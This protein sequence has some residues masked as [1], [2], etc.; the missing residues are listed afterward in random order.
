MAFQTIH[1]QSNQWKTVH[2]IVS[3]KILSFQ[4]MKS[5][6]QITK[7]AHL[8][9]FRL[10]RRIC[11]A[12]S[13]PG[14]PEVLSNH[15]DYTAY[16]SKMMWTQWTHLSPSPSNLPNERNPFM[17]NLQVATGMLCRSVGIFLEYGCVRYGHPTIGI[18]CNGYID[19]INP[20]WGMT[21]CMGQGSI[22]DHGTKRWKNMKDHE[23]LS[24]LLHF[25]PAFTKVHDQTQHTSL[26][27]NGRLS[28]D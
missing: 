4:A 27:A 3:F 1:L 22:F 28:C 5:T 14:L 12:S 11:L 2:H 18:P 20:H 25:S 23:R 26:A 19:R 9:W 13:P 21:I 6:I 24:D 10:A 16:T 15:R 8:W 17:T 7:K